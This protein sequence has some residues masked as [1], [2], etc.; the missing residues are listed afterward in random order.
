[1]LRV[2]TTLTGFTGGPGLMTQYFRADVE[3]QSAAARVRQ[4][5]HDLIG[6]ALGLVFA[7]ACTWTVQNEVDVVDPTNGETTGTFT[8]GTL[9]SA[10]GGGGTSVAPVASAGLI[11]WKTPTWTEGRRLQ[12][13]TFV[14]P[15]ASAA[16]H[17]D[18]AL[19]TAKKTAVDTALFNYLAGL[20]STDAQLVWSRPIVA[21]PTA[22]PP[23]EARVGFVGDIDVANISAKLAVLTSRR[24]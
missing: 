6:T 9:H 1:M 5:V 4:H 10:T 14:S 15:M 11:H 2:R 3:D 18:G 20:P 23:V 17:T 16:V 13:R 8:D 21:K 22:T 12:G 19:L 24:D 7:N